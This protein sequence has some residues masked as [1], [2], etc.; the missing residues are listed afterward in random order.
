[1]E[2][3]HVIPLGRLKAEL[4]SPGPTDPAGSGGG[5]EGSDPEG[6]LP[7]GLGARLRSD[8]VSHPQFALPPEHGGTQPVQLR[9]S[10]KKE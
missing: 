4:A 3:R 10:G 7:I 2:I 9:Y 5:G 8:G 1:M 6:T